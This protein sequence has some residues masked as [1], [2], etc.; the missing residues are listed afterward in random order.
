M[1]E[2]KIEIEI[3]KYNNEDICAKNEFLID[4]VSTSKEYEKI[5]NKAN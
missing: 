1:K 4:D 2:F 3:I 5:F